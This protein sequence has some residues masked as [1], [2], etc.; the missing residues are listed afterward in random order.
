[1][2]TQNR[3]IDQRTDYND[4]VS[5]GVPVYNGERF[6]EEMLRSL[7]AQSYPEVEI[8]ISDNASTDRTA[9]I[10]RAYEKVDTRI[11]FFC[12]TKNMGA[13]QNYNRVFALSRGPYFKWQAV[14]DLCEP[15]FLSKCV[16]AFRNHPEIVLAYT[17]AFVIDLDGNQLDMD[18]TPM[19]FGSANVAERFS[20]ALNAIPY[21]DISI[22]GLIRRDVLAETQLIGRYLASD[23]C[24]ISE[25]CLHGPFF[26]VDEPLFYRRKHAGNIG[27]SQE[28]LSFYDPNLKGNLSFPEWRVLREQLFN[29]G[30]CPLTIGLKLQ[31]LAGL[32]EWALSKRRTLARQLKY[33]LGRVGR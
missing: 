26:R 7:L 9:E 29:I 13:A 11:R 12:N 18:D 25:L 5:I 28:S 32:A 3:E 1:M 33:G 14:D 10:C 8:I 2:R 23:R 21:T 31:L 15:E 24:L 27:T 17:K 4:L 20:C 30:R 16:A 19:R 6:I 22:F